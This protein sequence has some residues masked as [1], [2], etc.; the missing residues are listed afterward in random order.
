M[1]LNDHTSMLRISGANTPQIRSSNSSNSVYS[2]YNLRDVAINIYTTFALR[3]LCALAELLCRPNSDLTHLS[4]P[5]AAI[6]LCVHAPRDRRQSAFYAILALLL[7]MPLRCCSDMCYFTVA[8]CIVSM[9][10]GET[11]S[12][13]DRAKAGNMYNNCL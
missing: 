8:F 9:N 3:Q 5:G 12:L 13:F 6:F 11:L 7:S 2:P 1:G 10:A 4:T